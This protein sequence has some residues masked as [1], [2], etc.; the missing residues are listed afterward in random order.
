MGSFTWRAFALLV[1]IP[2]LLLAWL[3]LRAVGAERLEV[4]QRLRD[5]QANVA[6]LVD[7]AI[8]NTLADV[9]RALPRDGVPP[10]GT[11]V[12][13]AASGLVTFPRDR[14]Y[15]GPFAQHPG[16]RITAAAW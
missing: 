1:A 14:V 7:A 15:F 6:Q 9:A 11:P 5:Q 16:E 4:E 8:A 13:F 10:V 2:A 12:V 3:G